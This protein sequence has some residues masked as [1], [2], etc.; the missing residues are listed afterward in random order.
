MKRIYSYNRSNMNLRARLYLT[1]AVIIFLSF[2]SCKKNIGETGSGQ[3][4]LEGYL[5]QGE[6]V[7]SIHLTQTISFESS[8]TIYPPVSDAQVVITWNSKSYTLQSI[9]NGYYNCNDNSL[10]VKV[11]DTYN[12]AVTYNGKTA[13]SSTM[14][15][16]IPTGVQLSE[17]IVYVDTTFT[18]GPP[19]MGGSNSSDNNAN[20]KITWD[21]NDNG[22]Y[23]VVIESTDPNASDIVKGTGNFPG[24]GLMPGRI[25]R[26][27]SQ[28]F[29]GGSYTLSSN[30]LEKYG[31]H[32]ARIYRVNQEYADLYKNRQ[33]DSRSLSEP[34]TN[35]V[36]GLG[37]FTGFS[38][39][40]VSF[41]VVNAIYK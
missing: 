28:P 8:D 37:I 31:K 4:V 29:Q 22:Y 23:Y 21:D 36:N 34:I 38:Y 16:S 27:R 10:E 26:F 1:I 24:G 5:F 33:Q 17:T 6:I 7:D 32:K 39:A 19:G 40:E 13:T 41:T 15:P 35:V 3:V 2:T 11:G 25:F 30:S 18:F 12:I 20:L 9:G 14:V